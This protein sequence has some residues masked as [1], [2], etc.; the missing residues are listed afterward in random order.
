MS[1]GV[2]VRLGRGLSAVCELCYNSQTD[3]LRLTVTDCIGHGST[4]VM[5]MD[6]ADA[7]RA[8]LKL[9]S[10]GLSSNGAGGQ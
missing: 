5:E 7:V 9:W 4:G 3:R 10:W 8:T 1:L 6:A 2:D